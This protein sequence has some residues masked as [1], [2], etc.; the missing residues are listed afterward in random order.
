MFRYFTMWFISSLALL[1]LLS[2]VRLVWSWLTIQSNSETC[3]VNGT[4]YQLPPA[5]SIVIIGTQ[6]AG[7]TALASFF[8]RHPKM[9]GS[10]RE[11]HFFDFHYRELYQRSDQLPVREQRCWL[12][13]TYL[14]RSNFPFSNKI[15]FE[16]SPSYMIS[17]HIPEAVSNLLPHAFVV[18]VLRNPVDRLVSHFNMQV[19][20]GR[21][22]HMNGTLEA[23]LNQELSL[24]HPERTWLSNVRDANAE[25]ARFEI[26]P[27][28]PLWSAEYNDF[29]H[30]DDVA[31]TP[32][33][34]RSFDR[35]L[36]RGMYSVQLERWLDRVGPERLV[37]VPYELFQT[38]PREVLEHLFRVT[39]VP[40][41]HAPDKLLHQQFQPV[42]LSGKRGAAAASTTAVDVPIDPAV[43]E[44]LERFYRPYN[45]RLA[46]LLGEEWR[47]IWDGTAPT[48]PEDWKQSWLGKL[49]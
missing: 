15:A 11:L 45:D 28:P 41:W 18:A 33:T 24:L 39:G 40:H 44:F 8:H 49:Q 2:N 22:P 30:W 48:S 7:T 23:I 29:Y 34:F 47:G 4:Y 6:K 20:L 43:R 12:K 10:S 16:K 17:P 25:D 9:V 38:H 42:V 26:P 5:P 36:Q 32:S 31:R 35:L 21:F 19:R 27:A 13:R 46:D 37:V 1:H 3:V 14:Q